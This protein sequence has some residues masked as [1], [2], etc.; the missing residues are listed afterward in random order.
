MSRT[1][2][3]LLSIRDLT[4]SVVHDKCIADEMAGK[5]NIEHME[6]LTRGEVSKVQD[7]IFLNKTA[8]LLDVFKC[9]VVETPTSANHVEVCSID[10][11]L[12][13]CQYRN[14]PCHH[15]QRKGHIHRMCRA[16]LSQ[17]Q[18]K[19]RSIGQEG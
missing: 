14:A 15:C 17:V 12:L 7:V 10:R 6:E 5:A 8:S 3:H 13:L 16:R 2:R 18:L 1:Q 19:R 9:R 4:Y 11:N